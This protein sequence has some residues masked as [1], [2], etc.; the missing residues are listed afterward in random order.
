MKV[1]TCVGS[2]PH[3]MAEKHTSI[4]DLQGRGTYDLPMF[5]N[6]NAV[7]AAVVVGCHIT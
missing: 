1:C 6:I 3:F 2:C 7:I 4:R 5:R